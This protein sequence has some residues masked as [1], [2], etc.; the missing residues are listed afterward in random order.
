[1][2]SKY[3][4]TSEYDDAHFYVIISKNYIGTKPLQFTCGGAPMVMNETEITIYNTPC[5]VYESG[6]IY[7]TGTELL[8]LSDNF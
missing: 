2:R 5:I 4:T 7:A 6:E 8:I 3:I 1:M